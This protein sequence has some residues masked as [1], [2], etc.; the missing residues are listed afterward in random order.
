MIVLMQRLEFEVQFEDFERIYQ[1]QNTE[2]AGL[3]DVFDS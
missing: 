3:M 2:A 1:N